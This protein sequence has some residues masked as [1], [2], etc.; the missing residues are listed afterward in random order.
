M[1]CPICKEDIEYLRNY[2]SGEMCYD[3]GPDGEY[4]NSDFLPEGGTNDYECPSCAATLFTDD[5]DATAFLNGIKE[6][7]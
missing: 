2:V 5:R 1:K 3:L 4:T 6:R 7:D